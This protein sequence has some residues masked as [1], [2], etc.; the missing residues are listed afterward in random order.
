M[1][2]K[3]TKGL[4]LSVATVNAVREADGRVG[5][6]FPTAEKTVFKIYNKTATATVMAL[7]E[8]DADIA[9]TSAVYSADEV[10]MVSS[11]VGGDGESI[12]FS[13]DEN[14]KT[15]VEAQMRT[16]LTALDE[17]PEEI[18]EGTP[19]GIFHLDKDDL[20]DLLKKGAGAAEDGASASLELALSGDNAGRI[21]V[22]SIDGNAYKFNEAVTQSTIPDMPD[23]VKAAVG[24]ALEKY[25]AEH[26]DQSAEAIRFTVGKKDIANMAKLLALVDDGAD[27]QL[28]ESGKHLTALFD[29]KIKYVCTLS[30][31]KPRK[32]GEFIGGMTGQAGPEVQI[33]R[34]DLSK[35]VS[36]Q[37]T[38]QNFRKDKG[39]IT[40]TVGE[41]NILLVTG[42][43]ADTR[44][45]LLNIKTS[46][47]AAGKT[48]TFNGLLLKNALSQLNAGNV[49]LR[50]T[51][52]PVLLMNGTLDAP[53]TGVMIGIMPVNPALLKKLRESQAAKQEKSKEA[54][55][56]GA[57]AEAEAES[58]PA[59]SPAPDETASE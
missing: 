35:A 26:T 15:F 43:D 9:G 59:E 3:I 20:D 23:A 51:P 2:T 44:Q 33:D 31:D 40:T 14:G 10:S 22:L 24:K 41:D 55:S 49:V 47:D 25:L 28:D 16:S 27:I 19:Y 37:L 6:D 46:E 48:V 13:I 32:V 39:G 58:A 17:T 45:R 21:M 42:Q 56:E 50:I 12:A 1:N 54:P 11:V 5:I 29:G 52:G 36:N 18:K 30:A 7:A 8:G 38:V 4:A 57:P 34:D 53:A